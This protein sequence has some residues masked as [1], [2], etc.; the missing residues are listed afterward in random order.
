M[1]AAEQAVGP[2]Y[3][4]SAESA[5]GT[6]GAP[7]WSEAP[8]WLAALGPPGRPGTSLSSNRVPCQP[9]AAEARLSESLSPSS[10]LVTATPTSTGADYPRYSHRK[11]TQAAASTTTDGASRHSRQHR[12]RP[13]R[14]GSG[15]G[16]PAEVLGRDRVEELPELLDFA[17]F[18]LLFVRDGH[19]RLVQDLLAGENL[20]AGAQRQRNGIGWPRAH[21]RAVGEDQVG[22]ED[23]VPQ[24]GDVHCAQ[25]NV[26]HLEHVTEQIVRERPKGN[27]ALLGEGDRCCRDRP[28]PDGQ[29]SI[30]LRLFQQDDGAVR[31]H[32]DPDADDLHLPHYSSVLTCLGNLCLATTPFAKVHP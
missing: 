8:G 31:W 18:V 16:G 4:I 2:R 13:A 20:R 22:V 7:G 5:P 23:T 27:H 10:P 19:A 9:A 30:A 28:D 24:R 1:P 29:V 26:Q 6:S 17:F 12:G 11:P 3:P 14:A 25:L 15:S 32:L 21:L